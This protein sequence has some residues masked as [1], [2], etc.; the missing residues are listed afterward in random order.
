M[1]IWDRLSGY[2]F[3]QKLSGKQFPS[4]CCLMNNLMN[5]EEEKLERVNIVLA[6]HIHYYHQ[7]LSSISLSE[8]SFPTPC[9]VFIE[10]MNELE[11]TLIGKIIIIQPSN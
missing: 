4:F 5:F 7:G 3:N 9:K 10:L 8:N 6:S 2:C 11:L 1:A